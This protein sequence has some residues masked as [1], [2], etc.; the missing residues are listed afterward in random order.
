MAPARPLPLS[1]RGLPGHGPIA[2]TTSVRSSS[3]P[4]GCPRPARPWP[5][6]RYLHARNLADAWLLSAAC[7]AA[8]P[9]QVLVRPPHDQPLVLPRSCRGPIAGPAP[10]RS[11]ATSLRCPWSVPAAAPSQ[12][13][14]V[15]A[16]EAADRHC[17]RQAR[18]W[19]HRRHPSSGPRIC[20]PSSVRGLAGRGPIAGAIAGARPT[21]MPRLSAACSAAAPSQVCRRRQ[22]HLDRQLSVACPA[23]APSQVRDVHVPAHTVEAV[24]SLPGRGPIAGA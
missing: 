11:R 20:L 13:P 18:P 3:A 6:R 10:C 1:V 24:R 4:A 12:A 5:H 22:L 7:P 19:L 8:V 17:P 21:R 23:A 16:A 9:S 2:G 14:S 15:D